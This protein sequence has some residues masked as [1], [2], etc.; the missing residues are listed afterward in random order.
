[1]KKKELI[2]IV[3]K[4]PIW[5]MGIMTHEEK[6]EYLEEMQAMYSETRPLSSQEAIRL[7]GMADYM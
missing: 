4:S 1:M 5:T 6:L 3:A 2:R 7:G